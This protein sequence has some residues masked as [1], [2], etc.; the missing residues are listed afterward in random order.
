MDNGGSPGPERLW[1]AYCVIDEETA[2]NAVFL[3]N[4]LDTY[5][6]N[7]LENTILK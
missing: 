1:C 3:R 6:K 4:I 5:V 7:M 2:W